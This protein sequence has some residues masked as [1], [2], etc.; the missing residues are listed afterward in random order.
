MRGRLSVGCIG[1]VAAL[2]LASAPVASAAVGL[3]PSF[4]AGG[5]SFSPPG[6]AGGSEFMEVDAAPD[7][8]ATV[9]SGGSGIVRFGPEG[10]WDSTFAG[11]GHLSFEPDPAAAG[12]SKKTFQPRPRP[13]TAEA[14]CSSSAPSTTSVGPLPRGRP[15]AAGN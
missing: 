8:S 6:T 12:D 5:L 7:G 9:S 1:V 4:G 15:R 10:T 11:S 13:S 14:G 3:D 2:L